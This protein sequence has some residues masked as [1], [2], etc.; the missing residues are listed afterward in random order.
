MKEGDFA[1]LSA[2]QKEYGL[3]GVK[4]EVNQKLIVMVSTDKDK[5][6]EVQRITLHQNQI[7]FKID[8]D[9]T[10]KKD[11]ATFF[12]SLDGKIWNRIGETLKMKY[13][14]PHFM[15][16]RFG[17]FNYATKNTGGYVDFDWF[18]IK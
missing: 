13:T 5:A 3:V 14:L 4:A 7:Y 17:L 16:Y 2:L 6:I 12:Y 10:N 15:G 1:G 9:F 11:E 8:C 18:R